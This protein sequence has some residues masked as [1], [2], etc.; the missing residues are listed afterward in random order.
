MMIGVSAGL[1]LRHTGNS[2]RSAGS[3]EEAALIAAWTSWA[4]A[5]MSLSRLNC[6]IS[7]TRPSELVEVISSTPGIA[8]NCTSSGVATDEA[9]VSALAPGI[10]AVIS[11]VGASTSGNGATGRRAKPITPQRIRASASSTMPM[12][13]PMHNA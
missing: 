10:C 6:R 12:G 8:L 4:A 9:M 7:S 1:I 5:S 13:W 3:R 2:G 11:M